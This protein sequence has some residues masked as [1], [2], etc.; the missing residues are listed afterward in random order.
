MSVSGSGS[1]SGNVGNNKRSRD[2]VNNLFTLSQLDEVDKMIKKR[3]EDV[4]K[5]VEDQ[6]KL[7]KMVKEIPNLANLMETCSLCMD[8]LLMDI[9]KESFGVISYSCECSVVRTIHMK[10]CVSSDRQIPKCAYCRTHVTLVAPSLVDG[11][12]TFKR[13]CVVKKPLHAASESHS[14]TESEPDVDLTE[15]LEETF[16]EFLGI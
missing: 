5:N 12:A 4:V 3:R 15:D 2:F 16:D 6:K 9:G 13:I 7:K 10:C 1:G 8:P 14:D 11:S